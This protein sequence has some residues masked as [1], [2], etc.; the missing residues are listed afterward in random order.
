MILALKIVSGLLAK[1]L[2]VSFQ[3]DADDNV[4]LAK[5]IYGRRPIAGN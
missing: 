5:A 4:G 1:R 3:V 2:G